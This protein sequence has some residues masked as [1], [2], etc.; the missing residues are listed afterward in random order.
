MALK[1]QRFSAGEDEV[2]DLVSRWSG[3]YGDAKGLG[4]CGEIDIEHFATDDRL[5]VFGNEPGDP[6][7]IAGHALPDR[8]QQHGSEMDA[9]G[10]RCLGGL[11][12]LDP[13]GAGERS[14]ANFLPLALT[15][16][17]KR[18]V[19]GLARAHQAE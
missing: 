17:L 12:F 14:A 4:D 15:E 6:N 2:A 18:P 3:N 16:R 9:L 5:A 10:P 11:L 13:P 8:G 19:C 7:M 1:A